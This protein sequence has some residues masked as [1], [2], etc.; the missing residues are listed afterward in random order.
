[1]I[2][3]EER[4]KARKIQVVR[5]LEGETKASHEPRGPN[6]FHFIVSV[7]FFLLH[8]GYSS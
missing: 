3:R 4:E 6:V 7:Q 2:K 5:E 8:L 1:M